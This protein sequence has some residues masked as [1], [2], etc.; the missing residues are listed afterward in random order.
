MLSHG[1]VTLRRVE[2]DDYPLIQEWQNDP[3]IFPRMDYQRPFTLDDIRKSEEHGAEK[4]WPFIIEVDGRPIG[5]CGLF[6]IRW[7]DRWGGLYI[8]IGAKDT[9]GK[10]YGKDAI[11]AL[12]GYAFNTLGLSLV[13]LYSLADN[14][15]AIHMYKSLGFLEE[16]RLRDRSFIDGTWIDHVVMSITRE[17]FARSLES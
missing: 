11:R 10:G 16:A 15:R 4:E 1:P 9:W 6:G 5:R 12:L 14:E 2:P 8:F 7:R 13:Q 3:E 17:E